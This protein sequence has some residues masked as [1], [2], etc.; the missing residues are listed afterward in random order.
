VGAVE[1][2]I[3]GAVT[4]REQLA[5]HRDDASC[6]SCHRKMDPPGFALESFDVMGAWRDRYRGVDTD[7]TAVKGLGKNGQPFE[8]HYGLPVDAAG[9]LPD[10]RPF[11]D[12]RE[13]KQLLRNE[14]ATVA[15]NL[16]KQLVIYATGAPVRFSDRAEIERILAR[17][18]ARDYGVRTLVHEVVQSE[19]FRRK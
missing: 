12:I 11:R 13:F 6:A 8:F 18:K 10:G 19:L 4:I 1:P 5:K 2:D 16:A 3:R 9:E 17:A 7:K 14:D 15:R